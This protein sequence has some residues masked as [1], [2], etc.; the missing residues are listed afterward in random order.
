MQRGSAKVALGVR[1]LSC[2]RCAAA[3]H[4]SLSRLRTE[5]LPWPLW[6]SKQ[7][8]LEVGLMLLLHLVES[9]CCQWKR[10]IKP[11]QCSSAVGLIY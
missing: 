11:L 2:C 9:E 6:G 8:A 5:A 3:A 7:Q 10:G 1:S 4:A